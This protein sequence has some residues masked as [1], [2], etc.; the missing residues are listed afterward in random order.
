MKATITNKKVAQGK[1]WITIKFDDISDRDETLWK[2]IDEDNDYEP[3]AQHNSEPM[4]VWALKPKHELERDTKLHNMATTVA[5]S[6]W[7]NKDTDLAIDTKYERIRADCE[8]EVGQRAA[9]APRQE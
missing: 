7:L 4:E 2:L 6:L 3:Q 8:E 1:T 9:R 5:H